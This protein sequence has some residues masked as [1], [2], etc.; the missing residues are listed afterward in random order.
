MPKI[1]LGIRGLKIPYGDPLTL[2][3]AAGYTESRF[4]S[5]YL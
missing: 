5:P 4:K 1:T 2:K 3:A